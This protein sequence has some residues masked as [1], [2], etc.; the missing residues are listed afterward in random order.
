MSAETSLRLHVQNLMNIGVADD[1][2]KQ[3]F[4]LYEN[5]CNL[6]VETPEKRSVNRSGSVHGERDA[7][8]SAALVARSNVR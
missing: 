8:C 6:G 2:V 1:Q 3:R 4:S 5:G 7:S